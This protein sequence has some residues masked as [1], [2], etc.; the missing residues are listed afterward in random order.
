MMGS[1]LGRQTTLVTPPAAAA[2]APLA[3]VSI[4]S[5]PGSRSWTRMST[6]PGA[7]QWPAQ[8]TTSASDGRPSPLTQGPTSTMRPSMA[9]SP[10]FSSR[11]LAGSRRRASTK[12]RGGLPLLAIPVPLGAILIGAELAGQQIEAGHAHGH[13]HLDLLADQ[14]PVDIVGDLGIDLDAAVHRPGMHDERVGPRLGELLPI[15]AVEVEIFADGGD[16][17]ALHAL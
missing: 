6:S 1:V 7:R 13:A 4:C 8:R 15:Q 2:L 10:P 5:S 3:M 14:A 9:R 17:G 16:I 11:P 12:A